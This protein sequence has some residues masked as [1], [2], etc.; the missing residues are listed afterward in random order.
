[1]KITVLIENTLADESKTCVAEHGISLYVEANGTTILADTGASDL[2]LSNA[3][4]L[5]CDI[6]AVDVAF[7]SHAHHDH[8]GGLSA[9]FE[10]NDRA[11]VYLHPGA[12]GEYVARVLLTKKDIGLDRDVLE[13]NADRIHYV[14]SLTEVGEGITIIPNIPPRFPPP[15]GNRILFR[16]EGG[17]LVRDTF[18]HELLLCIR[19]DDGLFLYTGCS[20]RGV[21]NMVDAAIAQ[22]P[23][24]PIKAV[25]GGFHLA[26]PVFK[27]MSERRDTVIN[28][29]RNLLDYPIGQVYSGH[30]TGQKAFGVLKSVMGDELEYFSTGRVLEL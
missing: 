29:G 11:R 4:R 1:L 2:F 18:D 23:D 26:H 3:E 16:R 7:I 20:H 17:R 28:I 6:A 25:L 19:E 12:R 8:G 30:C 10:A 14:D 9:F 27:G 5:G 22:F 13:A 24:V 21:V 15:R